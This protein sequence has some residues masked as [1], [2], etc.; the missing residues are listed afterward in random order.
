M[1]SRWALTSN[2]VLLS[3]GITCLPAGE[4]SERVPQ[5][6]ATVL[7]GQITTPQQASVSVGT[8]V[9]LGSQRL[10]PNSHGLDGSGMLFQLEPGLG[11]AKASLGYG[12]LG[13]PTGL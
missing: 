11:G 8:L 10:E 1:K 12:R 3:V 4:P 13:G 9:A 2:V 6:A 7:G 5:R